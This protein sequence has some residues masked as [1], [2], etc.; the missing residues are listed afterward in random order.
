MYI[1]MRV[2]V[3]HCGQFGGFEKER[4]K[5]RFICYYHL[6]AYSPPLFFHIKEFIQIQISII[7]KFMQG[8]YFQLSTYLFS[9]HIRSGDTNFFFQIRTDHHSHVNYQA[10][11]FFENVAAGR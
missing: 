4:K 2:C 1:F 6:Q 5:N 3:W 11:L 9:Y 7:Y 10:D 8:L